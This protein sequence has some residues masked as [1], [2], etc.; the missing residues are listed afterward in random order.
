MQTPKCLDLTV[1]Y[2]SNGL[3]WETERNTNG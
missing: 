2:I 1:V 3:P